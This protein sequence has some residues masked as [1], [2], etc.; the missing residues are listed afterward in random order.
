ME[1]FK[2]YYPVFFFKDNKKIEELLVAD[3]FNGLTILSEAERLFKE[4][5]AQN[6]I[7]HPTFDMLSLTYDNH[8]YTKK[9]YPDGNVEYRITELK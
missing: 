2:E 8:V 6:L 7:S 3:T 4:M 1:S 5:N 9:Y